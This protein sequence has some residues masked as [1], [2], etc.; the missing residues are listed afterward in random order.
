MAA[1]EHTLEDLFLE[2]L[3][4]MYAAEKAILRALPRMARTANSEE[5]RQAFEHHRDET[6]GLV[7]RLERVFELIENINSTCEITSDSAANLLPVWGKL[8][9]DRSQM[10]ETINDY[11]E[12]KPHDKLVFSA[13]AR[14]RSFLN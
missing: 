1:K 3:K 12:L 6:E 8:P 13:N 7:E 2:T 9:K 11:L 10:L 14:M 5:L 4:D